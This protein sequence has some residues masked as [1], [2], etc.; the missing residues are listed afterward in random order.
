MISG[1]KNA[2]FASKVFHFGEL[3]RTVVARAGRGRESQRGALGIRRL[4]TS[5]ILRPDPNHGLA[6][7]HCDLQLRIFA[8]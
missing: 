6:P 5:D 2:K 3:V 4:I 7:P 8:S 1:A